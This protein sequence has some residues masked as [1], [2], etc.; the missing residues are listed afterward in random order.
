MS[1]LYI[2]HIL[3]KYNYELIINNI[4]CQFSNAFRT[5][6]FGYLDVNFNY[7]KDD[8]YD[9]KDDED[10]DDDEIN[11]NNLTKDN[12][13]KWIYNDETDNKTD[14]RV[15][16]ETKKETEKKIEKET[17][18]ET[19]KETE[20]TEE[21]EDET[22]DKY[23]KN[24]IYIPIIEKGFKYKIINNIHLPDF[25]YE[26]KYNFINTCA[27]IL[28]CFNIK[29]LPKNIKIIQ[30]KN[31][32]I[33][34]DISPKFSIV[35]INFKNELLKFPIVK[36]IKSGFVYIPNM[37]YMNNSA[38]ECEN[39]IDTEKLE[40]LVNT[41][42]YFYSNCSNNIITIA[43]EQYCSSSFGSVYGFFSLDF[44]IITRLG[45]SF[46]ETYIVNKNFKQFQ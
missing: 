39:G 12:N 37:Y 6:S 11:C 3:N 24:T 36:Q 29:K 25:E 5:R 18:E 34:N 19:E 14:N 44:E 21:S 8:I 16:G 46:Y 28:N 40:Y 41:D 9:D 32:I 43:P 38:L 27:I 10:D 4:P 26:C 23:Y 20:E 31:Y 1:L 2:D 17:E 22:E 45:D 33:I 7:D 42:K 15:Y 13:D 30:D 35:E